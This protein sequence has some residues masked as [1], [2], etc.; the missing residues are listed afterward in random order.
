MN[1]GTDNTDNRKKCLFGFDMSE[2]ATAEDY[3]RYFEF[4]DTASGVLRDLGIRIGS[5]GYTYILDSVKIIV[6]RDMRDI[7]LSTDIYPLIARRHR[8]RS[9]DS[10]EHSIRHS[11]G[12]AY[13]DQMYMGE[14]NLIRLFGRRPT[15]KQFLMYVADTVS[16]SMCKSMIRTAG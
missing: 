5:N 1:K 8:I 2:P 7:R 14:K 15:N 13:S 6:D 11:I 9:Y 4:M 3:A 10:I 16:R 12:R